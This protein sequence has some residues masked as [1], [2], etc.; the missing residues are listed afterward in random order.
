MDAFDK[1]RVLI[2]GV[3]AML[4]KFKALQEGD[5]VTAAEADKAYAQTKFLLKDGRGIGRAIEARAAASGDGIVAGIASSDD[6]DLYRHVVMP[7]AFQD[8][9]NKRGL[10]GPTGIKLLLDHDHTKPAGLIRSLRYSGGKLLIE[11]QLNLDIEYVRD[12]YS[13]MRMLGGFN[14]SVGFM[15]QDYEIKQDKNKQEYLQ[16]NRGDLFEVSLVAFPGNEAAT[17][18]DIKALPAPGAGMDSALASI[19]RIQAL[20]STMK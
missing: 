2:I 6:L 17:L 13:A 8:A 14:F 3:K 11:A 20:L 5:A 12:R 15:L 18:T 9:I 4:T 7:G 10:T 19:N 16:I 1:A